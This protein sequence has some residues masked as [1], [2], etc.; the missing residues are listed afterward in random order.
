M[1]TDWMPELGDDDLDV[2]M[3]ALEAWEAKDVSGDIMVAVI[4]GMM[5][6]SHGPMPPDIAE[7]RRVDKLNAERDKRTRKERSVLLRAKLL[8]IRDR[9]RADHMVEGAL[10][11]G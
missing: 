8:T 5:S 10:G 3:E 11:R 4:D 6:R 7:K 1:T 2:L 9:R